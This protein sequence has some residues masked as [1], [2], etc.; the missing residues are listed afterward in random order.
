[1]V[2]YP[3]PILKFDV[4][5]NDWYY[6]QMCNECLR[7]HLGI[8]NLR[9]VP[10]I[11]SSEI[12]QIRAQIK[13]SLRL[14]SCCCRICCG[15][16]N[17]LCCRCRR[18]RCCICWVL[19]LGGRVICSV[20][21][22]SGHVIWCVLRL[23]GRGICCILRRD[24]LGS[25]GRNWSIAS[26][27]GQ[28]VVTLSAVP[29]VL[30]EHVCDARNACQTHAEETEESSNG[31]IKYNQLWLLFLWSFW[32]NSTYTCAPC[33]CCSIRVLVTFLQCG[34]STRWGIS[35]KL[36]KGVTF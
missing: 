17:C 20:L 15:R 31:A 29:V 4:G 8:Q 23:Y 32:G 21:R 30:F 10:Q 24:G 28:L 33:P 16:W 7:L 5:I 27:I 18:R 11:S 6:K 25:S 12:F 9:R 36:C 3:C 2:I 13:V 34:Q 14:C 19:R 22:L 1:M 35:P 26:L